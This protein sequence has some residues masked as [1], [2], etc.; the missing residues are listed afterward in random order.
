[1]AH[2]KLAILDSAGA[3]HPTADSATIADLARLLD[4]AAHG[5]MVFEKRAQIEEL[6]RQHDEMVQALT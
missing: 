1:M 6:F 2:V 3:V 5:R 4:N